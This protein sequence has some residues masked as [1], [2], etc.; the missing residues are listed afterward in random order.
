MLWAYSAGLPVRTWGWCTY[1]LCK[2]HPSRYLFPRA[3]GD[4]RYELTAANNCLYCIFMYVPCTG[5]WDIRDTTERHKHSR[6]IS[7]LSQA[8]IATRVRSGLSILLMY[9]LYQLPP[10]HMPLSILGWSGLVWLSRYGCNQAT[11]WVGLGWDVSNPDLYS[12]DGHEDCLK[13]SETTGSVRNILHWYFR[14]SFWENSDRKLRILLRY[15][16]R[17]HWIMH[18]G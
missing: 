7:S 2:T 5:C 14:G 16:S 11:V 4:M 3:S 6:Q 9:S 12:G 13:L 10:M 1:F 8:R 15:L 18:W 17:A